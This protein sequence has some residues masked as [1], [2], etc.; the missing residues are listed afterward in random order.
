MIF[1]SKRNKR[2]FR[3]GKNVQGK[4]EG[5]STCVIFRRRSIRKH[6][7]GGRRF[8]KMGGAVSGT[9]RKK[10]SSLGGPGNSR[11]NWTGHEI[12]KDP[13]KG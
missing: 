3:W 6:K 9:G 1:I 10:R 8:G 2:C 4:T 5:Y 12:K 11:R 7:S 13:K